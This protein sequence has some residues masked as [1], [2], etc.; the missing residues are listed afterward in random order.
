MLNHKFIEK[1]EDRVLVSFSGR[2]DNE[3]IQQF[4]NVLDEILKAYYPVIVFD[5]S[6]LSFINSSGIG[7]FLLFYKK[8]N[9]TN[10]KLR[11]EGIDEDIMTLFKA[12]RI[13]KLIPIKSMR[14]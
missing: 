9:N 10:S 12:I 6:E 1:S 2:I 7:K 4:Q 14:G 13:D 3:S 11:I 8:L 5:F